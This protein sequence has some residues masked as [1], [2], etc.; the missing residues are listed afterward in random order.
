M[1]TFSRSRTRRTVTGV[2]LLTL[3]AGLGCAA[4]VSRRVPATAVA[5][6][7]LERQLGLLDAEGDVL[8]AQDAR[9]TQE[10]RVLIARS[11]V[12]E[13]RAAEAV[14]PNSGGDIDLARTAH[15]EAA[16]RR[17]YA[18][19]TEQLERARLATSEATLTLMHARFELARAR[20]VDAAGQGGRYSV[21]VADYQ[22]QFDGVDAELRHRTQDEE[23]LRL[24][25]ETARKSWVEASSRLAQRT[26]GAQGSVWVQ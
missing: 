20:E 2:G 10:E 13:A 23:A 11:A 14:R 17:E 7:P 16:A 1:R 19:R 8:A 3:L 26:G 6:L 21:A 25:T 9:D 4:T 5:N 24:T 18:E 15:S 22:R 12:E